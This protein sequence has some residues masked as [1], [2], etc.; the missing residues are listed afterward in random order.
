M[1]KEMEVLL[2]LRNNGGF[3]L[4]S[5][6]ALEVF[7][8]NITA[9]E[10]DKLLATVLNGFVIARTRK[11]KQTWKLTS[12]GWVASANHIATAAQE[13]QPARQEPI[14][15]GFAR[16]K[17]LAKDNPDVTPQR[18]LQVAGR[19]I[20]DPLWDTEHWRAFR[21][22]NPEWFLKQPREWYSSD[23]E[24]T[25]DYPTRYPENPLTS[26]E[27]ETRPT[28]ERGWFDR[29][30]RQ[31][32][33]SLEPLAVEMSAAECANVIRVVKKVGMQAGQD[34]FGQEKIE[35]A[36]RLAGITLGVNVTL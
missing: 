3:S 26:K 12:Q 10:L 9:A 17:Q 25:E 33:A 31:P 6:V 8:N 29:A 22:Q 27:R 14:S 24:L 28:T 34:I 16:F 2:F 23:V 20:G 32:G 35:Q 36:H 5:Q 4:R 19:H 15:D 1:Q 21:A 18:L 13:A 11:N 7:S 30:M